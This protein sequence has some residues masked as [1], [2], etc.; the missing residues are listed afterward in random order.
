M[1]ERTEWLR[2]VEA[3]RAANGLGV[4]C[5]YGQADGVPCRGPGLDCAVCRRAYEAFQMAGVLRGG[6]LPALADPRYGT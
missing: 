4:A 1:F 2:W 6:T 5:R 3:E